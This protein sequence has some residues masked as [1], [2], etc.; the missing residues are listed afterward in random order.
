MAWML[1]SSAGS[2]LVRYYCYCSYD[3]FNRN[4]I[5]SAIE[6]Q[7]RTEVIKWAIKELIAD[8]TAMQQH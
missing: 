6:K 3:L 4:E 8:E 2:S 1:E 5:L 7:K